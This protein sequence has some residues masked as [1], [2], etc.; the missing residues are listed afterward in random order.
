MAELL[1]FPK[2]SSF[3]GWD[4]SHTLYAS[5]SVINIPQLEAAGFQLAPPKQASSAGDWSN[6]ELADLYR[7]EAILLQAGIKLTTARGLSDENDPWYV[8]CREDDEVFVHLARIDGAYVLESPALSA[9]LQGKDF[10]ALSDDFVQQISQRA[11]VRNADNVLEF[12]PKRRRTSIS[13]IQPAVLLAA[14]VW[15]L[16]FGSEDIA[17]AAEITQT[18]ADDA[19]MP[20]DGLMVGFKGQELTVETLQSIHEGHLDAVN[21]GTAVSNQQPATAIMPLYDALRVLNGNDRSGFAANSSILLASPPTQIISASLAVIAFS[22][23]FY[24]PRPEQDNAADNS[25]ALSN[26]FAALHQTTNNDIGSIQD[27]EADTS[28]IINSEVDFIPITLA[29]LNESEAYVPQNIEMK[30]VANVASLEAAG[31]ASNHGSEDTVPVQ[32]SERQTTDKGPDVEPSAAS[33]IPNQ[34]DVKAVNIKLQQSSPDESDA[35]APSFK[36]FSAAFNHLQSG[37]HF[38]FDNTIVISTLDKVEAIEVFKIFEL[39]K[40]QPALTENT[41]DSHVSTESTKLSNETNKIDLPDTSQ[42]YSVVGALI[43]AYNSNVDSFIM[44]FSQGQKSIEIVHVQTELVIIDMSAIDD[45][46]D[47][48]VARSWVTEDGHVIST[49]GHYQS[50]IEYGMS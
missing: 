18:L 11:K 19:E 16:Y 8:F 32:P 28:I 49:V 50:F 6:Q 30:L 47:V 20:V 17:A 39:S 23:G 34:T 25:G 21:Q 48:S 36:A 29:E 22:F 41:S 31:A 38:E 44:R 26:I 9:P 24:G 40:N 2:A 14:L 45:A 37:S 10:T 42:K 43:G 1:T 3:S 35:P 4:T 33:A 15:T 46:N 13:G 7:I 12:R 27:S 5:D